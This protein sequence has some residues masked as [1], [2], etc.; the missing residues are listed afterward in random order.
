MKQ[1]AGLNASAA[2]IIGD[3]AQLDRLQ[4][5]SLFDFINIKYSQICL[6]R[7]RN[8][9]KL[10]FKKGKLKL[11]TTISFFRNSAITFF[12]IFRFIWK[13]NASNA[14]QRNRCTLISIQI[15]CR[16]LERR[17]SK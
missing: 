8:I 7:P 6:A 2:N 10:E 5:M 12:K 11:S 13:S 17:T 1:L 9:P 14:P 3:P 4:I 15:I 16:V